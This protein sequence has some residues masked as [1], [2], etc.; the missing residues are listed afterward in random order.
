MGIGSV[1]VFCLVG[2]ISFAAVGGLFMGRF[3]TL[4]LPDASPDSIR[5]VRTAR[6]LP[7]ACVAWAAL[8]FVAQA[9]VN[10]NLLHRDI[11]LGD[12]W[13]APLPN[14]YEIV[15]VDVI[16]QG[17]VQHTGSNRGIQGVRLLQVAD[18]YL[19]GA[20]DSH[21]F[22]HFGTD[23]NAI[24]SYFLLDTRTGAILVEQ[25]LEA[26]S[27]AASHIGIA[28]RLE[29]IYSVYSRHRFTWF[30]ILSGGLMVLPPL[31]AFIAL[32]WRIVRLR[33]GRYAQ[34]A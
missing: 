33:S 19:L 21:S 13:Y 22:E 11:G 3:T 10:A 14:H 16:D 2:G 26:L 4:L 24:D 34:A 29:P 30:D 12:N 25:D 32:G 27:Q 7:F 28:T 20:S 1:L 18:P 6:R 8:V 15:F 31:A 9:T 23:S 5:M 17:I